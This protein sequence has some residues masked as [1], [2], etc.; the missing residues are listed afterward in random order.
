MRILALEEHFLPAGLAREIIGGRGQAEAVAARPDRFRAFASLPMQDPDA[1]AGE[2]RRAVEELGFVGV[3]VNGHPA[4]HFLDEPRFEPVLAA[5]EAL[6]VPIY[7][8]PTYPPDAVMRAYFSELPS[9]D[10]AARL[11]TAAWGWHA[12]T[13][14]PRRR[15]ARPGRP[16]EDRARQRRES[17]GPVARTARFDRRAVAGCAGSSGTPG[18][19]GRPGTSA[20][21]SARRAPP[22]R[23]APGRSPATGSR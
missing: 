12:E 10:V 20:R 8:H 19:T 15:S 2:A 22:G 18:L 11:S 21:R 16:G 14:V 13:G 7:V 4:G 3:M 23:P 6:G 1:A 17:A 9:A 5:I